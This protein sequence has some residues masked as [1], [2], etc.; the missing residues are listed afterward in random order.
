MASTV[1]GLEGW[2]SGLSGGEWIWS[3]AV[4]E[5]DTRHNDRELG[6]VVDSVALQEI[7]RVVLD[8]TQE[9]AAEF[10][11][12]ANG[13]LDKQGASTSNLGNQ[14]RSTAS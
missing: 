14:G 12:D 9:E 5:F 3:V 8:T 10:G 2:V 13:I 1:V 7:T 11:A 6:L 4:I